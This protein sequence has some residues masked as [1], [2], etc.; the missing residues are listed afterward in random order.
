MIDEDIPAGRICFHL[1]DIY[2]ETCRRKIHFGDDTDV[3]RTILK[4]IFLE[5]CPVM[6]E[7][8]GSGMR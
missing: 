6:K 4:D 7:E 5:R 1:N 2:K 3:N 8:I